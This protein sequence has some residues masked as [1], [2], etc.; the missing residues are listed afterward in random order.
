MCIK[1]S[2]NIEI[3]FIAL[4]HYYSK[5]I[6]WEPTFVTNKRNKEDQRPIR[7]IMPPVCHSS[8]YADDFSSY[9]FLRFPCTHVSKDF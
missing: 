1:I 5:V 2:E 8:W 9:G 4:W 3:E 7:T 6:K